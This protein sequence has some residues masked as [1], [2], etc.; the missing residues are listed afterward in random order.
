LDAPRKGVASDKAARPQTKKGK[1]QIASQREVL[2]PIPGKKAKE[3]AAKPVA[4]PSTRPRKT[5]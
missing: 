4:R 5:G 1:K 3:A 2:L